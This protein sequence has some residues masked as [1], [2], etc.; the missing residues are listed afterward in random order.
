VEP[1]VASAD[2]PREPERAALR[3]GHYVLLHKLGRGGMGVVYAAYDERLDRRVA[4]K[5]LHKR[6]REKAGRRLMR[7]AQALARLS[8]PHLVQIHDVGEFEQQPFLVMD[9]IEGVTLDQWR[10]ERERTRAEILA[11]FIAAG[12]GL[13]AA[14]A[15][16]VIHREFKPEN[17]MI[18]RDGQVMVMDFGL[19]RG[20]DRS[21]SSPL[22][23]EPDSALTDEPHSSLTDEP[24][25]PAEPEDVPDMPDLPDMPDMPD[26]P[27]MP[28]MPDSG[29]GQRPSSS[30]SGESGRRPR[31][32]ELERSLT[33]VGTILGTPGYMAPEQIFGNDVNDRCDQ[34]SF[35]ATLWEALYD[36]RPFGGR[37]IKAF[38]RALQ[39]EQARPHESNVVPLWLRK[40][41]ERG[42]A[43]EPAER[44]PSMNALLDALQ[45]DP[46]KRR[47]RVAATVGLLACAC[48]AIAGLHFAGQRER[49]RLAHA[50]DEQISSCARDGEAIAVDWNELDAGEIE[51]VFLT[52]QH[53]FAQSIWQHTRPWL[54]GFA[55]E[56]SAVRAQTC[57]ETTV[58][59]VRGADSQAAVNDCLDEARIAFVGLLDVLSGLAADDAHMVTSATA[60]AARLPQPSTCTNPSLLRQLRRPP[61]ELR[62]KITELRVR[63]ERA[64]ARSYAGDLE[65]A[66]AEAQAALTEAEALAWSP[67]IAQAGSLIAALQFRLG[68]PE[69]A[70]LASERAMLLAAAGDDGLGMLLAASE[71]SSAL[72]GLAN[73]DDARR[74]GMFGAALVERLELGGTTYEAIVLTR[75]AAVLSEMGASE[76]ALP[77]QQRALVIYETVLG[78]EHPSVALV[79]LNLGVTQDKLGEHHAALDAFNRGVEIV[80]AV[81]GPEHVNLGYLYNSVA[82]TRSTLGDLEGALAAQQRALAIWEATFGSDHPTVA[83]AQTNLGTMLCERDQCE[84]ALVL[85]QRALQTLEAKKGPEA[86]LAL[87][88]TLRRTDHV[89]ASIPHYED[90]LARNPALAQ[91]SMGHAFAL[92]HLGRYLEARDLLNTAVEAHRDRPEFAHMLA[93]LL[94]VAPDDRVRNGQRSLRLVNELLRG[95]RTTELGETL[96]M[97]LAE[98][99][100]YERAASIQREVL[101]VV[102]RGGGTDDVRRVEDNLRLYEAHRPSRTF[103]EG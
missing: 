85:H 57:V 33:A 80:T 47:R 52:T 28:D 40:V 91:A 98:T 35:C 7:E 78:P 36:L 14:H 17:V 71:L 90:V 4:I 64:R 56:W 59:H 65:R 55:S 27:D 49:E 3:L 68:E 32:S 29:Q 66:L 58:E 20:D 6:G 1:T 26:V 96:A 41:L 44:W 31:S 74:W 34:F 12:R 43:L 21:D 48:S 23:D 97:A 72:G 62:D 39:H 89:K 10:A 50:R 67:I 2:M 51:Q 102:R 30:S 53:P 25:S 15:K 84:E 24:D 18:R 77:H 79:L 92:I 94:A 22:T 81:Q 75:L 11:V 99:G 86:R 83:I 16:G 8:H 69:A 45:R 70:K 61:D 100:D 76:Q 95:G 54:D 42:L 63:L 60:A 46:T 87:A 13:A 82:T 93:R 19:A 37:S 88:E 5:L 73:Y 103:S 9:L 38:A 101:A